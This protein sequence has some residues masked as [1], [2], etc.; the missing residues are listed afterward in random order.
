MQTIP[1]R[2]PA[3]A[4]VE[5]LPA[6]GGAGVRKPVGR[7]WLLLV[8]VASLAAGA[9]SLEMWQR[10][11]RA[12]YRTDRVTR[13]AV[14]GVVSAEGR[15]QTQTSARIGSISAGQVVAVEVGVGD[16]VTRGQTMARLD[17]L[18]E[19]AAV[20]DAR[21]AVETAQIHRARAEKHVIEELATLDDEGSSAGDAAPG[22]LLTGTAGDAQLDL[23]TAQSRVER[24]SSRRALARAL[25]AR[26]IIRAPIDGI[27]L[28]R[29]I[30]PGETI[31][32]SPP[33]PPLFVVGSDPGH[34]RLE[35]EIDDADAARVHPGPVKLAAD[36]RPE[37]SFVAEIREIRP[38]SSVPMSA[39][40]YRILMDVENVE[41]L[42]HPGMSAR[43]IVPME[44]A[45][46]V[47]R[48][49]IAALAPA[50][51]PAGPHNAVVW[52]LDRNSKPAAVTVETG[53]INERFAEIRTGGLR[54]GDIVT[55]P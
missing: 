41:G 42:L 44:T 19:R 13:G 8:A 36:A 43:V 50:P 16:I 28:A 23:M 40:R 24:A 55:L 48:V 45:P 38:A 26:R 21:A 35:V 51:P 27:V 18:E 2:R 31:T 9:G 25:L 47:L 4:V 37:R 32:A 53:V 1:I 12:A 52:V 54:P 3:P 29:S 46:N 34:L 39:S 20:T 11:T 10:W 22:D 17:D 30:D 33:G 14:A 7:G 15:L 6:R 49:P 5:A